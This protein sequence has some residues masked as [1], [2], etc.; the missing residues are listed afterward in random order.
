MSNSPR[1][2]TLCSRCQAQHAR[3]SMRTHKE[4]SRMSL[5]RSRPSCSRRDPVG[6]S[7]RCS[8][9]STRS[10]AVPG[11]HPHKPP[12][13]LQRQPFRSSR[14]IRTLRPYLMTRSN[15]LR[16]TFRRFPSLL[17]TCQRSR[18]SQMSPRIRP[19]LR[20]RSSPRFLP[21]LRSRWRLSFLRLLMT[22]SRL[23]FLP[24]R[25][26]SRSHRLSR[27]REEQAERGSAC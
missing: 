19:F 20:S 9:P 25:R 16:P 3:M 7:D 1:A 11:D 6:R 2:L 18:S 17:P 22:R 21:I 26:G 8:N 13:S 23:R 4:R 15:R 10:A 5:G 14:S 12:P 27:R 24:C